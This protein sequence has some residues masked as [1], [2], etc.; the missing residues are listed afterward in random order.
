M[1]VEREE[2][3]VTENSETKSGGEMIEFISISNIY[4][5]ARF[6][7]RKHRVLASL[8][9]GVRLDSIRKLRLNTII[10]V[11]ISAEEGNVTI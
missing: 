6:I 3:L 9:R 1:E 2:M 4:R 8:K 11:M 10:L 5:S 7:N